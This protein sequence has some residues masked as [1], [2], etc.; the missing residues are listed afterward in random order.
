[1]IMMVRSSATGRRRVSGTLNRM[2]PLRSPIPIGR[3]VGAGQDD[4][5]PV[6]VPQPD[7]P[8]VR[9]PVAVRRVAVAGENDLGLESRDPARNLIKVVDLKPEQDTVAIGPVSRITDW[10][11]VVSDAKTMQLED[12][13]AIGNQP[14]ILGSTVRALAAE[15]VLVPAAA[16]FD[17]GHRNERLGTH[18]SRRGWSVR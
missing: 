13:H 2:A 11:V 9:S 16:R 5:V 1:M 17:I 10:I 3:P 6:R 14:L 12:E 8:V 7:L 4:R 15:E 18:P